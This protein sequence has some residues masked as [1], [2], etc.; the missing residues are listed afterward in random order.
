[1][2][3]CYIRP[4]NLFGSTECRIDFQITLLP[5][6]TVLMLAA[7]LTFLLSSPALAAED[8]T[9][10]ITVQQLYSQREAGHKGNL[11]VLGVLP[12]SA[13]DDAGIHAGDLI[14]ETNGVPVTGRDLAE[15]RAK[16]LNGAAGSTVSLKVL[17]PQSAEPRAATLVRRPWPPYENP[18]S[19][20]FHYSGPGNWRSERHQF[21]LPWAPSIPYKGLADLLFTPAFS[22]E[23]SPD[24]FRI[25][26]SGGLKANRAS[27]P[28]NC[29][30]TCSIII[31]A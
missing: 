19:D 20:P 29:K 24:F 8:S 9:V 1:M 5:N 6:S 28:N 10:G 25:S 15:I 18:A 31:A 26:A 4:Y 3:N 2:K 30:A 7:I 21:P 13:A 17:S 27:P 11:V 14:V 12:K 23:S 22:D 16:E